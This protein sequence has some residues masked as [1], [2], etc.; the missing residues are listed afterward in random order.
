MRMSSASLTLGLA[1]ALGACATPTK[2]TAV[3]KAPDAAP[4]Q[5]KKVI[6]AAQTPD[7]TR[8]RTMET[9]LAGRIANA[10]P[11]YQVLTPDE[12]RSADRARAKIVAAGF[13]AALIVRFVGT[14]KQTTYVPGTTYWGPAPYGS[15][16]GYWGYGWGAAYSPGYLQTD[17]VVTLE[18]NVY[19][20][21]NDALLWSSRS[22][23][24]SPSSIDD[25]MQ[26]VCEATV[27]EMK[28]QKVLS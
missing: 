25:L 7:D 5:F 13:D 12:S 10:T 14:E 21:S 27:R 11:S 6:V 18:S 20:I 24:I 28:R 16:S 3:W 2:L 23:T 22:D 4:F 15:M 8:R 9:Y 26:S 19:S 1:L 17:T